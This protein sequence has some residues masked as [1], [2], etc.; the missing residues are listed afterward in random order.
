MVR[1]KFLSCGRS[2]TKIDSIRNRAGQHCLSKYSFLGADQI[3]HKN[4]IDLTTEIKILKLLNFNNVKIIPTSE[5]NVDRT[6]KRYIKKGYTK[7]PYEDYSRSQYD[8][9]KSHIDS[10]DCQIVAILYDID[11]NSEYTDLRIK[12]LIPKSVVVEAV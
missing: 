8:E 7:Y 6:Y 1:C 3:D 11:Y 10:I 4:P 2:L 5:K 9:L 12:L